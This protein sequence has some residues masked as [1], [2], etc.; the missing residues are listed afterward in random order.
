MVYNWLNYTQNRLFP[1]HCT[2]CGEKGEEG[3]DLC[4]DCLREL[5]WNKNCCPICALPLPVT[6]AQGTL[7]GRCSKK[8][9]AYHR[10]HAA[11][12]YKEPVDYLVNKLK[13]SSHFP[14]GRL[15]GSLLADYLTERSLSEIEILLPVPLHRSRLRE[16]G[17]NQS[18]ELARHISHATGIPWSPSLLHKMRK[19]R[20]KLGLNNK[21]RKK[22]LRD[23]FHFDNR[24][25]YNHVALVDDEVTTGTT[26]TE[27]TKTL[28]KS[29]VKTVEIFAIAKTP[30]R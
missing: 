3:L 21:A 20:D 19:T 24:R 5:P 15:M 25:Q 17:F 27:I 26:I 13:F 16:R 4:P 22:N 30:L 28:I 6:E 29:G 8:Q 1:P 12:I 2:L 23:C 18:A 7:G 10:I 11:F 9:P 14:S